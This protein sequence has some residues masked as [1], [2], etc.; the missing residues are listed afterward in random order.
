MSSAGARPRRRTAARAR[1]R[2][3]LT[4]LNWALAAAAVLAVGWWLV[5]S[6]VAAVREV[7]VVGYERP[8]RAALAS[9]LG[10]AAA[11]G[12]LVRL[13][14]GAIR[15]AAAAFPWVAE[16]DVQRNWPA[17]VSVVITP[18][19]PVAVA[20]S[21]RGRGVLVDA[22]GTVLG[23]APERPG[24]ARLRL[25]GGAPRAGGM[26]GT[27]LAPALAFVVA[28]DDD[29]L[30]RR[31][32]GLR[33]ERGSLIG[34]IA[35]SGDLVVG[36]PEHLDAKALALAAVLNRLSFEEQRALRYVDVTVPEHPA[37]G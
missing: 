35:G 4:A 20:T 24:M 12:N 17:G 33:I 9:A 22:S 36:R 37:T 5:T 13:P 25:P 27:K 7:E 8:D 21:K 1:E 29:P 32:R 31:L 19:E 10:E 3:Q 34:S 28:L 26:L 11:E 23:R 18:A 6:P 14:V 15:E 30:A 2:C 16:V